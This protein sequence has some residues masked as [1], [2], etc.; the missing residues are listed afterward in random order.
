MNTVGVLLT[1]ERDTVRVVGVDGLLR[2]RRREARLE[3]VRIQ[4][5]PRRVRHQLVPHIFGRNHVLIV[6]DRV[7]DL[8][9]CLGRLLVSAA[10]AD[11]GR[12]APR[13]ESASAGNPCR[14]IRTC[15]YFVS[16]TFRLFVKLAAVRALEIGEFNQ[17]D[18]ASAGP[19]DGLPS[20]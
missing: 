13:G 12:L 11:R 5:R 3:R 18:L 15:G 7:V 14:R 16:I 4:L 1:S 20:K 9:E 17:R 19:F 6:E 2:V 10:R 8:P